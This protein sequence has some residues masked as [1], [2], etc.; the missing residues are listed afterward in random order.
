ML[1]LMQRV[2]CHPYDYIG[3]LNRRVLY[4]KEIIEEAESV[5]TF[6]FEPKNSI[7]WLSGQHGIFFLPKFTELRDSKRAFSIASTSSEKFIQIST[8]IPAQPSKF[9]AQ[10]LQLKIGDSVTMFGPFGEFY[11]K[12]NVGHIV[13]VAGGIGI[14]PFRS[15]LYDVVQSGRDDIKINLLYGGK[16]DTYLYQTELDEWSKNENIAVSY[17]QGN[18]SVEQELL[19]MVDKFGNN[20]TYYLS[21]PPLM[22]ESLTSLL[23]KSGIKKIISDPFKGY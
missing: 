10:L 7:G 3:I 4:L 23:S 18:E 21:G 17:L 2:L 14:T 11:L 22:V 5:Y 16:S 13:G 9:K 20:A 1:D 6:R 19:S 12:E 15:L 8:I